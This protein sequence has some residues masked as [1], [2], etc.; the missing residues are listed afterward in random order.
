MSCLGEVL[1]PGRGQ[2][3][4]VLTQLHGYLNYELGRA[5][6]PRPPASAWPA[7]PQALRHGAGVLLPGEGRVVLHR[8]RL[9]THSR[10]EEEEA[11][12]PAVVWRCSCLHADDGA[13]YSCNCL[14]G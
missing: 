3:V 1:R 8:M 7:A 11:R 6:L 9:M 2:V 4:N 14:S 10:N 12:V 5:E 13:E